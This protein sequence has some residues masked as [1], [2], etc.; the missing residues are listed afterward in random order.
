M[1]LVTVV[2]NIRKWAKVIIG[3]VTLWQL[4]QCH[5]FLPW[6]GVFFQ[7]YQKICT[8]LCICQSPFNPWWENKKKMHTSLLRFWFLIVRQKM[9]KMRFFNFQLDFWKPSQQ[10]RW[11]HYTSKKNCKPSSA[12]IY[13][14]QPSSPTHGLVIALAKCIQCAWTVGKY[15]AMVLSIQCSVIAN[16]VS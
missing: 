5:N 10:L 1:I 4:S 8:Q 2:G 14:N 6:N 7:R 15:K 12:R 13:H 11:V 3:V 16:K 9:P